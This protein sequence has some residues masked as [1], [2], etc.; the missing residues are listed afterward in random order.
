MNNGENF[1]PEKPR[2]LTVADHIVQEV[3]EKMIL[4]DVTKDDLAD[5]IAR[6]QKLR[7]QTPATVRE[8]TRDSEVL[9]ANEILR[10]P[11]VRIAIVGTG[12]GL[13]Q[14]CSFEIT[15]GPDGKPVYGE[16]PEFSDDTHGG[17]LEMIELR[18]D[19]EALKILEENGR[20]LT[21][22][23]FGGYQYWCLFYRNSDQVGRNGF[24]GIIIGW[25][26]NNSELD[27]DMREAINIR[28]VEGVNRMQE[29]W[30]KV[31]ARNDLEWKNGRSE[32]RNVEEKK[33]FEPPATD[34]PPSKS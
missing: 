15:I 13:T 11:G 8:G 32:I 27:R 4:G 25:P 2:E 5:L 1:K 28:K 10:T 3:R 19:R 23:N 34:L 21:V 14:A 24:K 9:S 17:G 31:Y 20:V 30:R 12:D 33:Y 7:S 18:S 16:A 29:I 26:E 6:L 22:N